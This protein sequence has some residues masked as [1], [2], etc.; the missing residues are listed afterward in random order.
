MK[1]TGVFIMDNMIFVLLNDYRVA[2][3][4]AYYTSTSSAIFER[5]LAHQTRRWKWHDNLPDLVVDFRHIL[6]LQDLSLN[7]QS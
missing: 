6:T 2:S 1:Y 5:L 3:S 7:Q 4:T